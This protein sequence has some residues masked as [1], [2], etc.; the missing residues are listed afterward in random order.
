MLWATAPSATNN[1][2]MGHSLPGE[3]QDE[4]VT[5]VCSIT[6]FLYSVHVVGLSTQRQ[7][8][9]LRSHINNVGTAAVLTLGFSHIV[10]ADALCLSDWLH[11]HACLMDCPTLL[12]T[13]VQY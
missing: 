3:F 1:A 12:W 10:I 9:Q 11:V 7:L 13:T 5:H 2:S 4:D 8:W 6:F